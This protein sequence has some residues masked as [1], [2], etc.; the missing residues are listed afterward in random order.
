MPCTNDER[1]LANKTA[2]LLETD[3]S[4]T[5][6]RLRRTLLIRH[7][8]LRHRELDAGFRLAE[9]EFWLI[10]LREIWLQPR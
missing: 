9:L 7:L 5:P 6:I 3:W 4:L 8:Q 2:R 10:F 1:T